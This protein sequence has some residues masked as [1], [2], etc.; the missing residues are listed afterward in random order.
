MRYAKPALDA[1]MQRALVTLEGSARGE[2]LAAA[3]REAIGDI[4]VV[5]LLYSVH[6]WATRVG[7]ARFLA[8]PLGRTRAMFVTP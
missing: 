6:N 3:R 5:P 1:L 8:N 7:A 2:L 4:A